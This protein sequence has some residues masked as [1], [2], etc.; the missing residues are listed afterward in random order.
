[1]ISERA[2]GIGRKISEVLYIWLN[3]LGFQKII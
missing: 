3:D 1:M 2:G